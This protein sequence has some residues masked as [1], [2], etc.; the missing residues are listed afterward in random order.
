ML[1]NFGRSTDL[2]HN[3]DDND[4]SPDDDIGRVDGTELGE[5]SIEKER[6]SSGSTAKRKKSEKECWPRGPPHHL[7]SC[8]LRR[9]HHLNQ[10]PTSASSSMSER[11]VSLCNILWAL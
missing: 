7:P 11:I 5:K 10:G 3:D 8:P 9:K 6:N 2:G 1:I 4:Q